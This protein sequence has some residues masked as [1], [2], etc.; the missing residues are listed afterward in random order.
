MEPMGAKGYSWFFVKAPAV[1]MCGESG[2]SWQWLN[3]D[4]LQ[5]TLDG[6][7]VLWTV[8]VHQNALCWTFHI[9]EL[10]GIRHAKK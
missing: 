8:V 10:A 5:Q 4:C 6:L 2:D 9:I 3:A 7:V 1:T